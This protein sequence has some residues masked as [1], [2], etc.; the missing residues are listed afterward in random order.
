MK[1]DTSSLSDNLSRFVPVAKD[2][3]F[4]DQFCYSFG[5]YVAE[6]NCLRNLSHDNI[7]YKLERLASWRNLAKKRLSSV[8][9][10][11]PAANPHAI[12]I[13]EIT[14]Q[15]LHQVAN[16]LLAT[17]QPYKLVVSVH[18]GMVYTN[19]IDLINQ[20]DRLPAL[21]HKSFARAS[22]VRK[23]NTIVLKNSMF[24]FRGYF[25]TQNLSG[26]QKEHLHNFLENQ[27]GSVRI[28]PALQRWLDQPFNRTQDYY[29][30]DYNTTAWASMLNLVVP[31]LLRKTM[32][33]ITG[34]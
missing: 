30:V 1:M 4:Y 12:P 19:D 24:E 11:Y 25:R 31:G 17:N 28:S 10:N 18:S 27:Q 22:V 6:A 9:R 20:L 8:F 14:A 13:T 7:D 32:P 33:I 21:Q 34:K 2:R 15:N 26:Q 3:L 23:K 29:F 16:V 5:F